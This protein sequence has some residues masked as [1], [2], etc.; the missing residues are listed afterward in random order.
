MVKLMWREHLHPAWTEAAGCL[1]VYNLIMQ[2]VVGE[3][4]LC[5]ASQKVE[6][7]IIPRL[8]FRFIQKRF[9][10]VPDQPAGF[11]IM[12]VTLHIQQ[13]MKF[14]VE[15]DFQPVLFRIIDR[16]QALFQ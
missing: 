12:T 16:I 4:M 10:C 2:T 15:E 13:R 9:R 7:H 6:T 3:R 8:P 11:N 14:R 1:I 5:S